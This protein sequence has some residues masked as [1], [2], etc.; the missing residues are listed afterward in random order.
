MK[1]PE[2]D[3]AYEALDKEFSHIMMEQINSATTRE[4]RSVELLE[5]I[6]RQ[7]E[8]IEKLLREGLRARNDTRKE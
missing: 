4:Q 7:L 8:T 1:K 5:Q 2:F 6:S 3:Q